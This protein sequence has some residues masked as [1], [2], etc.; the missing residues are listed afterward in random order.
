MS[1]LSVFAGNLDLTLLSG[2]QPD[3]VLQPALSVI[4]VQQSVPASLRNPIGKPA[5]LT[6]LKLPAT[7]I[8]FSATFQLGYPTLWGAVAISPN[9]TI[10]GH[11]GASRWKE[12][13]II[14]MG[15]FAGTHW[16]SSRSLHSFSIGL[17]Q[18]SGPDDFQSS[19][20]HLDYQQVWQRP[21][22]TVSAGAGISY[23][24]CRIHV[25]DHPDAS[26][27]YRKTKEYSLVQLHGSLERD[28]RENLRAGVELNLSDKILLLS[29]HIVFILK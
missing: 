20:I 1:P 2:T 22:W 5:I 6:A 25:T 24:R 11:L 7:G 16:Q 8:D 9:L 29:C 10:G 4:S 18:L 21:H 12:D 3:S 14:S 15:P 26:Q 17:Y 13:N 23:S 27:N 19:T 28:I